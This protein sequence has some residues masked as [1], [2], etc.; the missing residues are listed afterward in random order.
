MGR[1]EAASLPELL[2]DLASSDPQRFGG[3]LLSGVAVIDHMS[4]EAPCEAVFDTPLGKLHAK[5]GDEVD[6]EWFTNK[7]LGLSDKL[8]VAGV[9]PRVE[10]GDVVI[11]L[12]AW[13]GTFTRRALRDGA[14]K[15]IAV[16][17]IAASAECFRRGVAAGLADG[18]VELVEA[19]AWSR[20]GV[21]KMKRSGPNNATGGTEGWHVDEHG[22][23]EVRAVTVD[24]I[25][26]ERG[27]E[28]VDLIEL[29][30]EGA[31]RFALEGAR[32]TIR[33]FGPQIATCIHHLPGDDEIIPALLL[34][35]RPDYKMRSNGRHAL[36][37]R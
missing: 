3:G 7:Y 25:V 13:I 29:D 24:Q 2:S 27:L 35:I 12:G 16:E 34:E 20:P 18:R 31:D 17:P 30:L 21:V 37:Y 15:V 33:R 26:A 4:G 14:G 6:V 10:P 23:V 11:E 19:A 36:F 9:V 28:R 1:L 32:E 8:A 5:P 22:D